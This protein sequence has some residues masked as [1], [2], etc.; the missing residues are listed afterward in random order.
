MEDISKLPWI[1]RVMEEARQLVFF[2]RK[3]HKAL[4]ILREFSK[5]EIICPSKTRFAYMFIVLE[6]LHTMRDSLRQAV[7]SPLWVQWNDSDLP[8]SQ[9]VQRACLDFSLW[10]DVQAI[11]TS[12]RPLFVL[13]RMTD[14]EGCTLGL[15]YHFMQKLRTE[16][17]SLDSIEVVR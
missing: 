13:L 16:L 4:A 6:R 1:S 15:L 9:R 5:L 14:M 8:E 12:L 2:F 3:K 7:V 17:T 11:V 10:S